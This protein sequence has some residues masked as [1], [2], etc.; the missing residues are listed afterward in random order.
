[1]GGL[2]EASPPPLMGKNLAKKSQQRKAIIGNDM[3]RRPKH[4]TIAVVA[5][6]EE[7]DQTHTQLVS[8]V[9]GNRTTG[10]VNGLSQMR[11]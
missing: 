4:S 2:R 5:P 7:T 9:M 3:L 11:G 1:L 10:N 8:D 6:E